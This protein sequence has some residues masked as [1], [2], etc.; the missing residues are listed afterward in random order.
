VSVAAGGGELVLVTH[1][2]GDFMAAMRSSWRPYSLC[3]VSFDASHDASFVR[4]GV[5]NIP[6]ALTRVAQSK[7]YAC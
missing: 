3:R 7:I 1:E 5:I 4:C 2:R 6:T